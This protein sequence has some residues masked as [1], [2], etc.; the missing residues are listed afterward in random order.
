MIINPLSKIFI[1]IISGFI[2]S[3]S[4][5][6]FNLW[7][8][9]W[10]GLSPFFLLINLSKRLFEVSIYSFLF[11]LAYN[12][13]YLRWLFSLHPLDWL[14][15]S[16]SESLFISSTALLIAA[17]INSIYF[18]I[19][20]LL[21]KF[22]RNQSRSN[23]HNFLNILLETFIWLI[24]F[25]KISSLKLLLGFPWTLIEYSQ[26]KNLFLIQMCEF[27]GS[28]YISFLIVFFNITIGCLMSWYFSVEKIGKRYIPKD[29]GALESI[30]LN[31]IIISG[32]ILF[33]YVYGYNLYKKNLESYTQTSKTI[34]ILQ[35]NLP[36]KFTRGKD[37]NLALAK[38]RYSNLIKNSYGHLVISPEGSIPSIFNND[39][40]IKSWIKQS[41]LQNHCDYLAGTYCYKNDSTT[42]CAVLHSRKK[43]NFNFYHKKRLVPFG[44]YIPF[45]GILPKTLKKFADSAIGEGFSPG[46]KNKLI[47][48][49][50]GNI[51][52]SICFEIIFPGLI[53]NNSLKGANFLVNLSDLS[54]FNNNLIKEQFLAFGT[55]RAIENRK[56][57]II[58]T[59]NGISAFI[60]PNGKIHSQTKANVSQNLQ[61]WINPN[62]KTTFYV[63]YGW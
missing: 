18:V 43:A 9:A 10:I 4:A 24:I 34:S 57:L 45:Y 63:K 30:I 37:L 28:S 48:S 15:L 13:S 53:R 26:Y 12:L 59:N 44:E 33:S 22:I 54:W 27:L 16:N 31:L 39:H 11:G 41:S 40:G 25:N 50:T 17:S 8:L 29:P 51:G 60:Q 46:V 1:S 61:D 42:N 35:G 3:L 55:F 2:L 62:N 36:I 56:H 6:G 38:K 32:L 7:F 14:G 47:K 21:I 52:V 19:Y 58:V 20:A 5:P 49:C 23:S